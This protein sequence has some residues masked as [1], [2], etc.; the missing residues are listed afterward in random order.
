MIRLSAKH[1][2]VRV[3]ATGG[4]LAARQESQLAY[5]GF[6]SDGASGAFVCDG[7]DPGDLVPK[8]VNY[9]SRENVPYV[10]DEDAQ[11]VLLASQVASS[12]LAGC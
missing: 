6:R 1:G 9:F 12:A 10:L 7:C 3:E 5:W 2:R 11:S 4:S 8:L